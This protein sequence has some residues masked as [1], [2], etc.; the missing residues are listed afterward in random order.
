MHYPASWLKGA[1]RGEVIA[2]DLRMQ[3]IKGVLSA[4]EVLSE[5]RIAADFG[6]SRSP[7]R[8]ALRVLAGEGLI[9]LERMGAVV[10]GL[11]VQDMDELYDIRYLIESFAQQQ[12]AGSGTA[13]EQLLVRLAQ[14]IDRMELAARHGDVVEFTYQDFNFHDVLIASAGHNRMQHLWNSIRELVRTVMLVT[15]ESVFAGGDDR[16]ADVIGKHR[17]IIRGLE[18]RDEKIISRVVQNYFVDSRQTLRWSLD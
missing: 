1:S 5:N 7:V 14:F 4:N 15:T 3:I 11:R 16:L 13:L 8:E 9:R 17:D 2:C 18:S 6:T 12:L 10:M